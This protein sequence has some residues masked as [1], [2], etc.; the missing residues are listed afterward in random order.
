[1]GKKRA[2]NPGDLVSTFTGQAGM[3]I[4]ETEL[5][6]ARKSLREGRRPGHY[7]APGC[8][9]HPDYLIRIPVI[10]E[11]GQYD[12]M[13]AMNLRRSKDIPREKRER[14]SALISEVSSGG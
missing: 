13:R 4:S 2:F 14:L 7:F 3:V 11:D 6:S 12:V 10:F 5:A 1:M 9:L 8:C